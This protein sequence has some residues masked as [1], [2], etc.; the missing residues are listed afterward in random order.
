ML[1]CKIK[2]LQCDEG[3]EYTK[4]ALKQFLASHGI[5]QRFSCPKHPEQNGLAERKH[6]HLV[7]FG[8]I[9]LTHSHM[10]LKYWV[11][12]FKTSIYLINRLPT[13]VLEQ[14][15]PYE[16]LFHTSPNYDF[17]RVFGCTCFP[18]MCPYNKNKL[19]ARSKS[20]VFMGYSLNHLGYQCLDPNTG[21]TYI[22]R[23][24]LFDEETFPFKIRTSTR[25]S[26]SSD[27]GDSSPSLSFEF[28]VSSNPNVPGPN[29][30]LQPHISPTSEPIPLPATT[31]N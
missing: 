19:E 11:E 17:I 26:S 28:S 24:V 12:A 2:S 10:P 21:R 22:T 4:T 1:S 6:H 27:P 9:L 29:S 13:R 25:Q 15:S 3:G 8:L 5:H 14:K 20:C 18:L 31:S 30:I 16:K 23:H 7:N